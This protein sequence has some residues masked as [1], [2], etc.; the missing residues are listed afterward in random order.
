MQYLS[1]KVLVKVASA[2]SVTTS[3][4]DPGSSW[5]STMYVCELEDEQ[6]ICSGV[7]SASLHSVSYL[8]QNL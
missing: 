5:T 3:Q 6:P 2:S 8:A 1:A 7:H 4:L